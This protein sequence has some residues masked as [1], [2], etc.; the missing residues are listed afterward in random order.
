MRILDAV[1]LLVARLC[2]VVAGGV[3]VGGIYWT[4]VT[5]GAVTVLEV[6]LVMPIPF[7]SDFTSFHRNCED[8]FGHVCVHNRKVKDYSNI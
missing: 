1:D 4:C 3:L 7:T 2:P 8:Y 6:S 5:F